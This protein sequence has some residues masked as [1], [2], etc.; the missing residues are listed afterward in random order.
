MSNKPNVI[1]F[2]PDQYRAHVMGHLGDKAAITPNFDAVVEEDAVSFRNAFCQ[3]TVCTPSR[4]SFLTGLYPHTNGHRTMLHMLHEHEGN[5]LKTMKDNGYTVFWAGKNDVFPRINGESDPYGYCTKRVELR[6][7]KDAYGKS[8]KKVKKSW[9]SF[10]SEVRG[11]EK[12]DTFYSF[13]IGKLDNDGEDCYYDDDYYHVEE[14]M[15]YIKNRDKTKPFFMFLSLQ[16]PH[17]PYAVEEPFFSMVDRGKLPERIK[18]PE[19]W[20][21]KPSILK[22]IYDGQKMHSWSEERWNELRATYYGMCAKIDKQFGMLVQVLK[23]E[24]I[25]D[26]TALFT[27]SDHGDFTGD[28]GLVEKTQNTFEDVLS[29]VPLIVKPPKGFKVKAGV[30]QSLVELVDIVATVEDFT[31]VKSDYTHFGK[32]LVEVISGEKEEHRDAV[33]CEG[34]RLYGERHCMENPDIKS[35]D[36][37]PYSPRVKLQ[38]RDDGPFHTKAIMCRTSRY[39]Y[40]R[41]LYE[42]DEL[43]D[44]EQDPKETIN[45][46]GNHAYDSIRIELIDRL[47]THYQE[48]ADIVPLVTDSR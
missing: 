9:H 23:E 21:G 10:F 17:P 42:K 31:G 39:K 5:I 29:N 20:T 43:Y 6:N 19:D 44:L 38:A 11:E 22:G 32:S 7:T 13:Y 12:D 2:N 27:F 8:G 48:T 1:L 16:Y 14:A 35:D 26:D 15:D 28:Y 25:Y 4:C 33:F 37:G 36:V 41:R 18:A 3:N 47:C 24:G 45:L 34:G 30:R 46:I 40:V